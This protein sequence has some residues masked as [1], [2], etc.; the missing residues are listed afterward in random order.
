MRYLNVVGGFPTQDDYRDL[1]TAP[2]DSIALAKALAATA[3]SIPEPRGPH[4]AWQGIFKSGLLYLS[5][6][7]GYRDHESEDVNAVDYKG[8]VPEEDITQQ[9]GIAP[10]LSGDD[11]EDITLQGEDHLE[12]EE[13]AT[14]DEDEDHDLAGEMSEKTEKDIRGASQLAVSEASGLSNSLEFHTKERQSRSGSVDANGTN[15][16]TTSNRS[17]NEKPSLLIIDMQISAKLRNEEVSRI[18]A[19]LRIW[20]AELCAA[21][22]EYNKDMIGLIFGL[23]GTSSGL[24]EKHLYELLVR[25]KWFMGSFLHDEYSSSLKELILLL[26][27]ILHA[28]FRGATLE[29]DNQGANRFLIVKS[30]LFTFYKADLSQAL[31]LL[32]TATNGKV[33]LSEEKHNERNKEKG[34]SENA[35]ATDN[36]SESAQSETKSSDLRLSYGTLMHIYV[37]Y[38]SLAN[39][40]LNM[41]LVDKVS[42]SLD[43]TTLEE[44]SANVYSNLLL[45]KDFEDKQVVS[46]FEDR[47]IPLLS[48][49]FNYH[50]GLFPDVLTLNLS[51]TSF[52]SWITGHTFSPDL[53]VG[54][55]TVGTVTNFPDD[56]KNVHDPFLYEVQQYEIQRRMASA[57]E[58][59]TEAALRSPTYLALTLKL[60]QL[61]K[62]PSFTRYLTKFDEEKDIPLLDIWLSVSSYVHHY[63]FR[64]LVN[65]YGARISLLTL[66]KLTSTKSSTV[67]PLRDYKI[68][69]NKWKLCHQRPPV[70]SISDG[71][72]MKSALLYI[73]DVVQ[74]TL[75][76][77][78]TKKLDMDNC[79]LALT[80]LYQILLEG[81]ESP[82]DDLQSYEWLDLYK[83][84]VHFVK[85]VDK[86]CN[87]EDVKYV[88]EEVFCIFDLILSPAYDHII[89]RSSDFWLLG[90]H[91]AKSVNFDLFYELL[92]HYDYLHALFDK[93]IIRK[94]NFARVEFTFQSLGEKF[95]I[96]SH[97]ELDPSEVTAKLNELSLLNDDEFTPP[98][99]QLSKFNYAETFKYLDKYHDYIDFEKQMEI[100]DI[101]NLLYDNKWVPLK[102]KG[103]N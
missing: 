58:G 8:S 45:D 11:G 15:H 54:I 102:V 27:E 89:E 52:F 5:S 4:Q 78:L 65:Q 24:T 101:F 44:V 68:N 22:K 6:A 28:L 61:V 30:L 42:L 31:D 1:F 72:G 46:V 10:Q 17:T 56:A 29:R 76:F 26:H 21:S 23:P 37:I 85:F 36:P 99:L 50:Y 59:D 19:I 35:S 41:L 55:D 103:I 77:N 2:L 75:R 83:T 48:A 92:Q 100:L 34:E 20:F 69:E 97:R 86:N 39:S 67:K 33:E 80:V 40:P 7:I 49:M 91:V 18:S 38:D 74:I 79:K 66:L 51:H 93:Y 32:L 96:S 73:V 84:L 9:T 25:I 90:S 13:E 70:I 43:I 16:H 12:E 82:F 64:S 98:L 95:D 71:D 14:D 62:N 63:Q 81:A 47:V 88:I 57:P 87:E 3:E 94:D 60:R 53:Y